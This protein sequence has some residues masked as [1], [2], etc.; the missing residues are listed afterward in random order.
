MVPVPQLLLTGLFGGLAALERRAFLQAMLSRPLVAGFFT[1][2]LW[3]DGATGLAVGLF[4]ELWHL[5][6]VSLGNA[7][8]E[9]E[10]FAAV[11]ATACAAA[12]GNASSSDGTPAAWALAILLFLPA[13]RLGRRVEQA[14]DV[15][16]R[17]YL[18]RAVDAVEAGKLPSAARMNLRA[19][20]PHFVFFSLASVAAGAVGIFLAPVFTTL[21]LHWVRSLAWAFPVLGTIAAGVAV[22]GTQVKGR[23]AWASAGAALAGA[24]GLWMAR[25][26]P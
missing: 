22:A 20:W 15:R 13:G 21:P 7:Q 8:S 3:G 23:A 18:G 12:L 4:F 14:L 25:G 26:T 24:A 2:A 16:A 11:S 1:G 9:H 10:T 19:M 5:G 6:S 17:R